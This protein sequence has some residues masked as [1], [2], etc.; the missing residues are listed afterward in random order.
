MDL[1]EK[2][3]RSHCGKELETYEHLMQCEQYQEMDRPMVK[4]QDILLLKSG[5]KGR[6]E[7][8]RELGKEGHPKVLRHII[9][10][11][12]LSRSVQ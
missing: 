3:M 12:S 1:A 9:V 4:N 2:Y 10:V 5:T 11:K 7:V 6:R 8:E